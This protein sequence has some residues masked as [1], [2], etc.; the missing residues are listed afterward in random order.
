MMK[1]VYPEFQNCKKLLLFGGTFDPIHNG[2][3]AIAK[4]V[5][6][7]CGIDRVIFLPAGQPAH[8]VGKPVTPAPMRVK[9]LQ[10][11]VEKEPSFVVSLLDVEREGKTYTVDTLEL[12]HSW[13]DSDTEIYFLVGAD[14]IHD[15]PAWRQP[16]KILS[17]CELIAV[18]RPGYDTNTLLEEI[19]SL[20]QTYHGT[21][22]YVKTEPMR[23]SS[24]DIRKRAKRGAH[25][26]SMVPEAVAKLIK[27]TK[28]YQDKPVQKALTK[29]EMITRLQ[30]TLSVKRFIHTMGVA[31]EAVKL[32]KLY[33]EDE[34]QAEIAG[35]LHDCAKDYPPALRDRLCKEYKVPLD[36][37]LKSS[38]GLIH[39]F[40]GAEVAKREYHITDE[41]ILSAIRY[42][43]TGKPNMTTLEKIIFIADY[44]EPNR[45][46]F[47]GLDE[48]RKLA[49][50]DLD[51][52]M[53]FMLE[54]T[55]AHVQEKSSVLH[56]LSV[57]TLHYYQNAIKDK[58]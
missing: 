58:L 44:I 38:P 19:Q 54:H 36:E 6:E 16:E 33:H 32:A 24:S 9:M 48:A 39:P 49:Y 56:P 41:A 55:I 34:T 51:E 5:Q 31:Q 12:I 28:L 7:T 3:L 15:F 13:T 45:A 8:K 26:A 14:S 27:E 20:E 18:D 10:L 17:L 35:L 11:A 29:Q 30:D 43:T 57:E 42:H 53:V 50:T 21:I 40:L 23:I 52:T 22:H 1:Q 2:H 46:P 25:I 37:Y 47:P 4:T